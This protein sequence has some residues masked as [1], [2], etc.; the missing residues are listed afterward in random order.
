MNKACV[1]GDVML[2]AYVYGRVNRVNPE[3]PSLILSVDSLENNVKYHLGGAGNVYENI[4]S[5][6][7]DALLVSR[8]GRDIFADKLRKLLVKKGLEDTIIFEDLVPT[9]TKIRLIESE[10]NV[11]LLRVD[12]EKIREFSRIDDVLSIIA[13]CELVVISDYNKGMITK[14]LIDELK[15]SGKKI[16]VDAKPKN[17]EFYH[18]VFAIKVNLKE[19]YEYAG[20]KI[21][22]EKAL[23]E[24]LMEKYNSNFIITKAE[25]FILGDLH[26]NEVYVHKTGGSSTVKSVIG[27]GD[28]FLS[29]FVY[30]IYKNY[31]LFDAC[32]SGYE[33]AKLSVQRSE[34]CKVNKKD[35]ELILTSKLMK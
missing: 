5:L 17:K 33:L 20:G 13:N 16:I 31:N 23:C 1:I 24:Y 28:V 2:D 14:Q 12:I 26:Q 3:F 22:D 15:K 8:V 4:V 34:T 6:G 9:I 25:G 32:L 18:E 7:V 10:R 30:G 11:I 27:A 35:V 21:G 29:G 19:A